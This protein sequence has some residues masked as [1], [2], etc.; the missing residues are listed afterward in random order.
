MSNAIVMAISYFEGDMDLMIDSDLLKSIKV[1]GDIPDSKEVK[2][3]DDILEAL[4]DARQKH[5]H[6]IV[7]HPAG[8]YNSLSTTG[9]C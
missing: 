1:K 5:L 9:R 6:I 3:W 2:P 8:T 4:T 7:Q